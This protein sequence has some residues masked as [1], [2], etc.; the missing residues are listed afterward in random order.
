MNDLDRM[1]KEAELHILTGGMGAGKS[2]LSKELAEKYDRVYGTDT[3]KAVDGKYVQPPK[4]EKARIRAELNKEVLA[5]SAAGERVLV[6][7]FHSMHEHHAPLIRA[8]NRIMEL[9]AGPL[10]RGYS[11]AR[12]SFERNTPVIPDLRR[13]L[14]E[15]GDE[16]RQR[17]AFHAHVTPGTPVD[18]LV[19]GGKVTKTVMAPERTTDGAPVKK[20]VEPGMPKVSSDWEEPLVP[21]VPRYAATLQAWLD[22]AFPWTKQAELLPEIKLQDHQRDAVEKARTTSGLWLLHG[23]GSGKTLLSQAIAEDRGGKVLVVVPAS[24][25]NNYREQLAKFVTKDRLKDYHV[26]SYD[27]IRNNPKIVDEIQPNTLIADEFHRLRNAGANRDAIEE[28]RKKVP[29]MVG[30]SGSLVSNHPSEIV[31]L[32]NLVAGKKVIPSMEHFNR[33]YLE[34]KIV[35]VSRL[36]SWRGIQPGVVTVGKNLDHFAKTI[37]P[38][39]HRFHGNPEWKQH[40]PEVR[41]EIVRVPMSKEQ[42]ALYNEMLNS[43]AGLSA[44]IKANL[45]PS[46]QESKSMTAFLTGIRQV[47]NAPETMHTGLTSE[48]NPKLRAISDHIIKTN[49]KDPEHKAIVYSNFI[50]SGV[51]PIVHRVTNHGIPAQTFTGALNDREKASVVSAYNDGEIRVMG[52]SPAGS[53]GLDLKKTNVAHVLDTHWNPERRNQFIGRAARFKSHDGLPE[54]KKVVHVRTYLAVH[55]P[56]G[57]IGKILGKK[58]PT[59]ADEWIYTRAQEKDTLNKQFVQAVRHYDAP[60]PANVAVQPEK[61]AGWLGDAWKT[62]QNGYNTATKAVTHAALPYAADISRLGVSSATGQSAVGDALSLGVRA[63]GEIGGR[64]LQD[65]SR[66]IP[67]AAITQRPHQTIMLRNQFGKVRPTRIPTANPDAGR[68][69]LRATR[70]VNHLG[71]TL[72]THANT[73]GEALGQIVGT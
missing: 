19:R 38:F 64:R 7:G 72:E 73:A 23:L 61:Q 30:L 29:F 70:Q 14:Q 69:I 53:E 28:V 46:R 44:K 32:V 56:P 62:V 27:A 49:E 21:D 57:V 2:T 71:R 60:M 52:V 47:L 3:G 4:E 10:T 48:H 45:P 40:V 39:I 24:L 6:E 50:E 63:A 51:A 20:P 65:V 26:Y 59:S 5:R 35:P 41:E 67:M 58:A 12:R 8:A 16:P 11:V 1:V 36:D 9:E 13:F 68:N 42:E 55:P 17:A 15:I 25:R 34:E 66:S 31:P 43:D 33:T 22:A 37:D 18:T 54:D